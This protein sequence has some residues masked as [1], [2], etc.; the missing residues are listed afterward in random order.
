MSKDKEK[1][2]D[3]REL[4]ANFVLPGKT[5]ITEPTFEHKE[6]GRPLKEG[7]QSKNY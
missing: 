1:D 3:E 2:K 7:E 5:L 6:T 4:A